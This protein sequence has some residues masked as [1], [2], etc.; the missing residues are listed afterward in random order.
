MSV[1]AAHPLA[2]SYE[3]PA[4]ET[5]PFDDVE[6]DAIRTQIHQLNDMLDLWDG[7]QKCISGDEIWKGYA[8]YQLAWN[9]AILWGESIQNVWVGS[10]FSAKSETT[11]EALVRLMAL[12]PNT[13]I[14]YIPGGNDRQNAEPARYFNTLVNNS[15]VLRDYKA[16]PYQERIKTFANG[17]RIMFLPPTLEGVQSMRG[18]IL[19]F[20][21]AQKLDSDVQAAA[22]P[23]GGAKGSRRFYTGVAIANSILESVFRY[24]PITKFKIRTPVTEVIKAGIVT[25][26]YVDSAIFSEMLTQDWIDV[27]YNCKWRGGGDTAFQP[28]IIRELA[29][30]MAEEFRVA[31][32][33]GIDF[34]PSAGH[35]GL[36]AFQDM[37]GNV[38][39]Y[40]EFP[41]IKSYEGVLEMGDKDIPLICEDG[42][43][44]TGYCDAL[45]NSNMRRIGG[46][47]RHIIREVW[48]DDLKGK[49]VAHMLLLQDRKKWYIYKPGCPILARDICKVPF[50]DR[51]I[52]D[53]EKAAKAQPP[54]NM[55][56]VDAAIH[57]VAHASQQ[58][59]TAQILN[60][61]FEK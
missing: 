14:S 48:N 50:N 27:F 10:R 53:K 4:A 54:I 3:V 13:H 38:V 29:P 43:T 42:G 56:V 39:C 46:D 52:P 12:K 8:P 47:R 6:I 49:Q 1:S 24:S 16:E 60:V 20:D 15:S 41:G 23:Q 30:S 61:W 51:C 17:S 58:T 33:I 9:H 26:E 59:A 2:A 22:M 18:N 40:K 45:Q 34:N 36:L 37:E 32:A 5:C 44:N 19:V 11:I 7:I 31:Q 35:W 28:Q 55:H 57:A 21:E 25:K